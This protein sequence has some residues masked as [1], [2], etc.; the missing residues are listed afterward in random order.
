MRRSLLGATLT[1]YYQWASHE[2]EK[3]FLGAQ[4][5]APWAEGTRAS[6]KVRRFGQRVKINNP[7]SVAQTLHCERRYPC[8]Q[9]RG[10][11]FHQ[12]LLLKTIICSL[13]TRRP[14]HVRGLPLYRHFDL[15]ETLCSSRW[16]PPNYPPTLQYQLRSLLLPVLHWYLL[17]R[18]S[19]QCRWSSLSSI[20]VFVF[21]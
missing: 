8:S 5:C 14:C 10:Y 17:V 1:L 11:W 4:G 20:S 12:H 21:V 7:E 2:G 9:Q 18:G 3:A 15:A 13:D 19:S 6:A 16:W